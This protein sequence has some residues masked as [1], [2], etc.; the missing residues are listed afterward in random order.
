MVLSL[1]AL[2]V[3]PGCA[4]VF[5]IYWKDKY[6]REPLKY[7][8]ISF[9]LGMLCIIPAIFIQ[10]GLQPSLKHYFPNNSISYF[11]LLAF[12]VVALSEELCKFVA[13]RL[14]AY[15]HREFDEPFDGITYSVMIGM[16]FA[17]LENIEYVLNYGFAT[18]VIRMFMSVPAHATFAVLMGYYMGLAKF[19]RKHSLRHML[20]GLLLST[21]FHGAFDF[22]LFLQDSPQVTRYVSNGLLISGAVVSY[23]IAIL[24]SLRSIR[25]HHDI[26]RKTWM[27]K[28]SV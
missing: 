18:G 17:T 16:G 26:S 19:D 13:L 15:P 2:A 28:N 4:I 6:D 22:F 11:S 14:Y 10:L 25:L 12:I 8:V 20:R 1:L 24:M 21:F 9:F 5:Y 23:A 27:A 7:L 3:A